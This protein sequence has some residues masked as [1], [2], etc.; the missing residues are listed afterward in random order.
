M[1]RD[2]LAVGTLDLVLLRILID[3]GNSDPTVELCVA[4]LPLAGEVINLPGGGSCTINRIYQIVGQTG[5]DVDAF[6]I[7][8]LNP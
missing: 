5:G 8:T 1:E 6:A 2:R 3:Q 4:Q 7:V